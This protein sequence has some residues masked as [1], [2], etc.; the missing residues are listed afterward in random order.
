LNKIIPYG[1]QCIDKEDTKAVI[2]TLRSDFITQGQKIKEF[3][4]TLCAYTGA[5]Y[6]VAVS[7]GT[8]ALHIA[9]LAAGIKKGDEVITS[10]ITFVASANCVLYCSGIPLFADIQEDTVNIDPDEIKI[11]VTGKT[12]AIIPVHFSGHPCDLEE[13]YNIA[14]KNNLTVIEDAAHALGA[15]YKGLTIGSCK[16]SDMAIF[17]FHPVKSITTGEGGAVLTNNKRFYNKLLLFRTHG[18]T[19][20]KTKFKTQTA[21]PWSYEMQELGFNYRITDFQCALGISQFGKLN[22]FIKKRREIAEI[23]KQKLSDIQAITV[24]SERPYVKSAWH[25]YCVRLK[26]SSL[27]KSVFEK[28]RG[29]G[30]GVQVH[31]IPVYY[32]PYYKR[33]GYCRGLCPNAEKYYAR[34][35]SLPLYPSMTA[36]EVNRVIRISR[37]VIKEISET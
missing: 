30:L 6:A 17:S 21:R 4:Q 32:H 5:K 8:A 9:C 3:E 10:P 37:K 22:M 35:I 25:I 18:I 26:N 11:K 19:K 29:Q 31:Y 7:S 12:K 14:K 15:K 1:H 27:R 24:P 2:K 36:S 28:L 33:L 34:T 20:E 13:I 16:F 23:Y